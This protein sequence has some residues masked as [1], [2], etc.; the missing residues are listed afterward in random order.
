M[1]T[2][3][4]LYSRYEDAEQALSSLKEAGFKEE[5]ITVLA[6]QITFDQDPEE[7]ES[8]DNVVRMAKKNAASGGIIGGLSGFIV[9]L[10]SILVPG[11]G[12]VI[13]GG[14][15]ATAIGATAAGAGL[16]AAAGGVIGALIGQGVPE[17]EAQLYAEGVKRGGILV[18]VRVED[19]R[20]EVA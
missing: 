20:S 18:V 15:L 17:E 9:G 6:R 19:G 3:V 14:A 12:P 10:G 2:L 5:A 4:A 11:L 13:A 7:A 16:G 8:G 1:D